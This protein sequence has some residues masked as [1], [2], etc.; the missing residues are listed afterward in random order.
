MNPDLPYLLAQ[1]VLD[2]VVG[3]YQEQA[4]PLPERRYIAPGTPAYDCAQV[5]VWVSQIISWSNQPN[6]VATTPMVEGVPARA[7]AAAY[8][9]AILR[10]VPIPSGTAQTYVL[11]AV[12]DE[13]AA[14]RLVLADSQLAWQALRDAS[15]ARLLGVPDGLV[16]LGWDMIAPFGGLAGGNLRVSL[17]LGTTPGG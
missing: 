12:E 7:R 6:Q 9:L 5:V 10:D 3:Y 15:R 8:N 11:P 13:Q 17:E 16:F 1:D 4:V 2:T 14:A